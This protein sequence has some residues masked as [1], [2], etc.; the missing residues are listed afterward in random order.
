M[1]TWN[2][3]IFSVEY[4]NYYEI[5]HDINASN[6]IHNVV[7]IEQLESPGVTKTC[8]FWCNFEAIRLLP[9]FK[10]GHYVMAIHDQGNLI[11]KS[12]SSGLESPQVPTT[13]DDSRPTQ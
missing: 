5:E 11:A 10:D 3:H 8:T 7:L 12:S 1:H 13:L 2:F 9:P 6:T 4:I